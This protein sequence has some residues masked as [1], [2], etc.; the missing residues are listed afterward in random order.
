MRM[1]RSRCDCGYESVQTLNTLVH[2][3]RCLA[4]W[5]AMQPGRPNVKNR[6]HGRTKTPAH[7]VWANMNQRCGNPNNVGYRLYGGRGIRV[8]DRW[9]ESFAAFLEDM[10][11]RPSLGHSL[12]RIDVNGNYEPENCRWATRI[13]Q[14]RNKRTNARI[15]IG[16]VTKCIAEWALESP[17]TDSAIVHRLEDGWSPAEAVFYPRTHKSRPRTSIASS[18]G[19]AR[20]NPIM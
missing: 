2:Y 13:E 6:T 7:R 14:M 1:V 9:R 5:N 11:E 12:D 10:G 17:V 18:V 20:R 15:T 3:L 8:C 16:G 4:C 19:S